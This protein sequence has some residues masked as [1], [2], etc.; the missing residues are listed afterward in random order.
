MIMMMAMIVDGV[1]DDDANG[2]DVDN[3][4]DDGN[5]VVDDDDDDVDD[6]DGY[7]DDYD[8]NDDVDGNDT[9]DADDDADGNDAD[10]DDHHISSHLMFCSSPQDAPKAT[11][12]LRYRQLYPTLQ[13]KL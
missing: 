10:D 4:D 13:P 6:N 12:P 7:G 11:M 5:V 3:D 2:Y 9:V 1:G 8:D